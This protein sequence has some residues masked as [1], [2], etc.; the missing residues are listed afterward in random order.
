M[1]PSCSIRGLTR[2]QPSVLS[3]I[4]TAPVANGRAAFGTIHG[5][6]L[7]DS[8]PAPIASSASPSMTARAACAT[9]SRPEPQRRLTVAPGTLSGKPA[10]SS[11]IRAT[12]RLSSP[13]WFAQ[14][15]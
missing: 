9:A 15:M 7:I 1:C 11:A 13:A 8:T 6:R 5:A 12:S 4:S 14:P 10:S 2:R 3:A